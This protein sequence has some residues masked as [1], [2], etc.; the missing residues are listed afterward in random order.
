MLWQGALSIYACKICKATFVNS[1]NEIHAGGL[2]YKLSTDLFKQIH[3]RWKLFPTPRYLLYFLWKVSPLFLIGDFIF[4]SLFWLIPLYFIGGGWDQSSPTWDCCWCCNKGMVS[5]VLTC[6]P[7][8]FS[9][10]ICSHDLVGVWLPLKLIYFLYLSVCLSI[11]SNFLQFF[12][13]AI[14][15]NVPRS[16]FLPVKATSDLLLVQVSHA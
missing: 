14:G 9:S 15:I 11:L 1:C 4:L 13:H 7:W 12:D 3:W 8:N 5:L 6:S 2:T 16:R 10:V